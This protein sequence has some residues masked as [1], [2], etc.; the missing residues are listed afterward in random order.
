M[1]L[2]FANVAAL[3]RSLQVVRLHLEIDVG[4][5]VPAAVETAVF[6]PV[7]DTDDLQRAVV[8]QLLQSVGTLQ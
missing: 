4:I 1:N 7:L 5:T 6:E 3:C 8:V 2:Q